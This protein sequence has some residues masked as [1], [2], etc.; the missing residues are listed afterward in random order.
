MWN[1][2]GDAGRATAVSRAPGNVDDEWKVS[3]SVLGQDD[4]RL[5]R[6]VCEAAS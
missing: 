5:L 3:I 2:A 6:A 4:V 1:M